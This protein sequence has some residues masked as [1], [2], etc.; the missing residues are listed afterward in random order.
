MGEREDEFLGV[1]FRR[2]VSNQKL[3]FSKS[4]SF[5]SDENSSLRSAA[6]YNDALFHMNASQVPL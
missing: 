6:W 2:I 5:R 3:N 1:P 4:H